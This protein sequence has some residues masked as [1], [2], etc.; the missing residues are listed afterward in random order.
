MKILIDENLSPTLVAKLAT[1]GAPG[2]RN[3]KGLDGVSSN[4]SELL[5]FF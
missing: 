4:P 1:K 5:D 2:R 3:E